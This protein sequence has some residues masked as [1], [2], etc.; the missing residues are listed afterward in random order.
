[1]ME[2]M[3][4]D[5]MIR[6]VEDL[7]HLTRAQVEPIDRAVRAMLATLPAASLQRVISAGNGD[8]YHAVRACELAFTSLGGLPHEP[9]SA[10]RFLDYGVDFLPESVRHSVLVAG[11]SAS[12]GTTHVA[13]LLAAARTRGAHTVAITGTPGSP[14]ARAARHTIP[15]TVPDFGRSPGIRTY[16]ASVLGLFLLA[17]GLGELQRNISPGAADALRAEIAGLDAT[18]AATLAACEERART[19]AHALKDEPL[20]LFLGSG[21]SYGTALFAAAKVVEA[22][23]L[24]AAG[25]ELEEWW[26]VERFAYPANMVTILI[27]P[28]GRSHERAVEL[29]EGARSLG[30]RL[31]AVVREG[32]Q[33]IARHAEFVFPV[34]GD[35]REA[36]SPLVYHLFA[37]YLASFLAEA[38]GRALFQGDNPVFQEAIEH[39]YAGRGSR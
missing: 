23:G 33:A 20:L 1:M 38:L 16:Q 18:I 25:Q 21:P 22:S 7:P 32:D 35:V 10:Q 12:G 17:I 2:P 5:A 28:P 9:L 14:V 15:V 4:P 13:Q 6:Q 19:A 24:F 8:S 27:A 11:V 34:Q 3:K 37:S 30:R 26:H 31:V 36:F 29:A 39:Y